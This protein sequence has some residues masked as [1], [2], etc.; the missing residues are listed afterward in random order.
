MIR[1]LFM[2]LLSG[3]MNSCGVI[4]KSRYGNGLHI[5]LFSRA[6]HSFDSARLIELRTKYKKE[7]KERPCSGREILLPDY[8]PQIKETNDSL[9][10]SKIIHEIQ[11]TSVIGD[12]EVS[13]EKND[14]IYLKVKPFE[15]EPPLPY[16]DNKKELE[17]GGWEPHAAAAGYAWLGSFVLN[18]V[19]AILTSSSVVEGLIFIGVI[20]SSLA[21]ILLI[22]ALILAIIGLVNIRFAKAE[23]KK[24][25]GEG[26]SIAIITLFILGIF[27]SIFFLVLLLL[28]I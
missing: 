12:K 1:I 27:I 22:A 24:L 26:V 18:I 8:K 28:L 2:V 15:F 6:H 5:D 17:D 7:A 20:F 3:L 9:N 25:K 10:G 19:G 13:P 4:Q 11:S 16:E 21:F 23:G 14:S